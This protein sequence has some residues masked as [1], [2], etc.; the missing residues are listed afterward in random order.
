VWYVRDGR[1]AN[2]PRRGLQVRQK[3]ALRSRICGSCGD[4]LYP[5]IHQD[6]GLIDAMTIPENIGLSAG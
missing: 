4:Q 3:I 2:T 1:S 6:L 5:F